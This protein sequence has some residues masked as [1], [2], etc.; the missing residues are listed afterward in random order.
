ME[1]K[2]WEDAYVRSRI[3]ERSGSLLWRGTG[4]HRRAT[5]HRERP[6][7]VSVNLCAV[8]SEDGDLE[9]PDHEAHDKLQDMED[10]L[11]QGDALGVELDFVPH[12]GHWFLCALV[13]VLLSRTMAAVVLTMMD[14]RP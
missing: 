5:Y 1:R 3:A 7:I 11:R 4:I 12:L 8:S 9:T 13:V 6:A 14:S 10:E 2:H